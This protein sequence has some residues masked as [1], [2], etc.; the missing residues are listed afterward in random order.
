MIPTGFLGERRGLNWPL[1]G[2]LAGVHIAGVAAGIVLGAIPV[3][4]PP[5][6]TLE[7]FIVEP[8][9]S[10]APAPETV[11]QPEELVL[12]MPPPDLLLA[13]PPDVKIDLPRTAPIAAPLRAVATPVLAS[14]AAEPA[15][16]PPGPKAAP[17]PVTPPDF[18][19]DQL[20]N[21]GPKYP[22]MSRRN[23]EQGIVIL[24]VLVSEDGRAGALEIE[25]S[26]GFERLDEAARKT[27]RKWNFLPARQAGKPVAAWVLV[28][29]TFA[30]GS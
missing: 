17:V 6:V 30:L 20:G 27:V 2:L 14:V 28:P 22:Y 8:D 16:A 10:A 3:A 29:V 9:P 24:R 25:E 4:P 5:T 26:S 7:T 15:P 1:I 18:S 23:R 21:P 19:A 13:P 12:D 11:P